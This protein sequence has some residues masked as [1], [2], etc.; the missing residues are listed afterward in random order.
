M[1]MMKMGYAQAIQFQIVDSIKDKLRLHPTYTTKEIMI[2]FQ[3]VFGVVISYKKVHR[4][5]EIVI[6][7][8]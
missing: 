8:I 7:Q 5:K 6:L 2:D 1:P 4:G 3:K